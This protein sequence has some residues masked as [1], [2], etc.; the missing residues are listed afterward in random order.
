MRRMW[1][2]DRRRDPCRGRGFDVGSVA[3]W[4]SKGFQVVQSVY[5]VFTSLLQQDC[6]PR[7]PPEVQSAPTLRWAPTTRVKLLHAISTYRENPFLRPGRPRPTNSQSRSPLSHR[8]HRVAPSSVEHLALTLRQRVQEPMSAEG[9]TRLS[10]VISSISQDQSTPQTTAEQSSS[11]HRSDGEPR[12]HLQWTGRTSSLF[13]MSPSIDGGQ[14]TIE[15]S[16]GLHQRHGCTVDSS[17]GA[18]VWWRDKRGERR[19]SELVVR[20]KWNATEVVEDR[21]GET[22]TKTERQSFYWQ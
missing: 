6:L 3:R 17:R 21:K 15:T 13:L 16:D 4:V 19:K 5:E 2:R 7:N 9:C 22:F 10:I 12:T 20:P 18:S 11:C 8:L 1:R 14:C